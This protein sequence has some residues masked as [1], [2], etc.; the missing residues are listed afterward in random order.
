MAAKRTTVYICTNCGYESARWYGKCPECN[1]WNTLE[2]QVK[3]PT[4]VSKS[5]SGSYSVFERPTK[6]SEVEYTDEQRHSSGIGEFDRVLGGGIVK[7]SLV[8][9]GGDPGIG[10]STILLQMCSKV[11]KSLKI[12][13][14]SGEESKRQIR[15]RAD[16]LEVENDNLYLASTTD[17]LEVEQ[18][19]L[20]DKPDILIIDSIQTMQ[21]STATSSPGSVVQVRECTSI[22]MR[23]AKREEVCVFVVGHVNKDG[24]IAG[25]KVLEHIV[26]TVLY[27]EGERNLPYRMLRAVKNRFGSTNE[28]GVFEMSSY[29]LEQ[30]ENPSQ[31][32][33]SG[34]PLQASGSCIT[35]VIEGSRPLLVEVQALISKSSFAAPRRTAAGFD[36]NRMALLLAVTEKRCGYFLGNLDAYLNVVGGFRLD[37]PGVD[38][39]VILSVISSIKDKPIPSDVVA[40]GEVGLSGEIRSVSNIL[41]RIQEV[42]RLG[43]KTCILPEANM[44]NLSDKGLGIKLIGVRDISAA[45]KIAEKLSV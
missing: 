20:Q 9:I 31:M 4:T 10:K 15:L 40:I 8:L 33:L 18:I 26:D 5:F 27:F 45:G 32:L 39:A 22:L 41:Q 24:A 6:L 23:L 28:V 13:Y 37:D 43:F 30:V 44:K 14:I 3:S 2:E 7:G 1:E 35:A 17:I 29:G 34:R 42:Q 19:V 25:P 11:D 21:L 38:L 12:I 36:Y 16:R